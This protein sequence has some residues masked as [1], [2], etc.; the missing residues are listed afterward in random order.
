M[1]ESCNF[2]AGLGVHSRLSLLAPT[3]EAVKPV[4]GG[5]LRVVW[6]VVYSMSVCGRLRYACC[7]HL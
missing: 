3:A 7:H 1:D 4:K 5:V 6:Y 2:Y